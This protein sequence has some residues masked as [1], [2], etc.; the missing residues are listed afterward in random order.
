MRKY[1]SLINNNEEKITHND[2]KKE[3]EKTIG[4]K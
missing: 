2:M 4:K 3:L 1:N